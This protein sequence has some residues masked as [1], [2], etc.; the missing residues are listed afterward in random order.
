MFI[1]I[2]CG[3]DF[4]RK[5]NAITNFSLFFPREYFHFAEHF[6]TSIIRWNTSG[7]IYGVHTENIREVN[8]AYR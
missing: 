8:F 6:G 5:T 3:V 1:E 7:H 4:Q 2:K